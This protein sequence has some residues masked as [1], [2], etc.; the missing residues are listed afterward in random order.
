MVLHL[1]QAL[2]AQLVAAARRRGI[3]VEARAH[4]TLERALDY[5][6]WFIGEVEV[7]LAQAET[8][9]TLTHEAV[10]VRLAKKLA[11]YASVR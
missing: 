8:G 2:D 4:E 11:E 10:G 7:G 5:D 9:E 3:S 6:A 1:S